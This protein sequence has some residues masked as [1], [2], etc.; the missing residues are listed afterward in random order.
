V[1]ARYGF[2]GLDRK[3]GPLRGDEVRACWQDAAIPVPPDPATPGLLDL[4]TV[5]PLGGEWAGEAPTAGPRAEGGQP[6]PDAVRAE[7]V[8]P[9]PS[10]RSAE[11]DGR[12]GRRLWVEV[13]V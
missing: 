12:S 11:T 7:P 5:A 13:E 6:V 8:R 9:P 2:C 10:A 1:A 4:L 3:R